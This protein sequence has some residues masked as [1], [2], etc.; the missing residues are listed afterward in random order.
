MT[1]FG[2][3]G[4]TADDGSQGWAVR[5]A[6]GRGLAAK[7]RK[8]RKESEGRGRVRLCFLGQVLCDVS[9]R[10]VRWRVG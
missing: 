8:G 7:K 9:I 6:G 1:A 5:S 4:R 3:G 10:L 2:D